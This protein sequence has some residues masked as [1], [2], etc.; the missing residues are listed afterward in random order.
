MQLHNSHPLLLSLNPFLLTLITKQWSHCTEYIFCTQVQTPQSEILTPEIL[1]LSVTHR[2]E[3]SYTFSWVLSHLGARYSLLFCF[4]IFS[5][6]CEC[7]QLTPTFTPLRT[8]ECFHRS[9]QFEH[10][11]HAGGGNSNFTPSILYNCCPH[12]IP[13]IL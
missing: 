13:F 1:N 6:N 10:F 3:I 7:H 2:S 4:V 12:Q 5:P 9:S 8:S 11:S